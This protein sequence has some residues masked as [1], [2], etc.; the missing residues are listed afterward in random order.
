MHLYS[1][2]ITGTFDAIWIHKYK[3]LESWGNTNIFLIKHTTLSDDQ[4][5]NGFSSL[6]GVQ[7]EH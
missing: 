2:C 3:W 5:N 4:F 7:E 6:S 1:K